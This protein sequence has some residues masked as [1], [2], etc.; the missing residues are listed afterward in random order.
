MSGSLKDRASSIA[1]MPS[2]ADKRLLGRQPVA[3]LEPMAAVGRAIWL[4]YGCKATQ[5]LAEM[6]ST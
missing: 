6:P 1:K 4:S 3:L 2:G 5:H